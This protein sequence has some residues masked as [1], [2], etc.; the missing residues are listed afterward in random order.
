VALS[1]LTALDGLYLTRPLR[2]RDILVD[3]D[4]ERFMRGIE[5]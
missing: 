1:R 2:P 5:R 4:V 3:K